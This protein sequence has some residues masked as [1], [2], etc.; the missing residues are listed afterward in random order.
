MY[1]EFVDPYVGN[2]LPSCDFWVRDEPDEDEDEDED[3]NQDHDKDD[4]EGDEN[5]DGYSE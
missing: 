3:E 4:E 2:P 5:S 1:R